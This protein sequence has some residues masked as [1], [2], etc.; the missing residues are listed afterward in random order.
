MARGQTP[1]NISVGV[2][3]RRLQRSLGSNFWARSG[4]C[5]GGA[6]V[7]CVSAGDSGGMD[8]RGALVSDLS[9][10]GGMGEPGD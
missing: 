7:T 1:Y 2:A 5:T 8:V 3:G 9:L 10:G 6:V 4:L